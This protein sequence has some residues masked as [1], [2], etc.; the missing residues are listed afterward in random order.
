ME[1]LYLTFKVA[2]AA[3]FAR[4]WDAFPAQG[5][6]M[7]LAVRV[8]GG[9]DVLRQIAKEGPR[10][11][12]VETESVSDPG[13]SV[14]DAEA[15]G[16][17]REAIN[18]AS[19]FPAPFKATLT[20]LLETLQFIEAGSFDLIG[21]KP[22]FKVLYAGNEFVCVVSQLDESGVQV[23]YEV[24]ACNSGSVTD[25]DLSPY[26]IRSGQ[27]GFPREEREAVTEHISQPGK[28]FADF[29]RRDLAIGDEF[30]AVHNSSPSVGAHW[31]GLETAEGVLLSAD[32]VEPT[33]GEPQGGGDA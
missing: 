23:K 31:D 8:P 7:H 2:D 26:E 29:L 27:I 19:G 4:L 16:Q 24:Q 18:P 22:G 3:N 21:G 12:P 10:S 11:W 32:A 20:A 30:S 5:M 1:N 28:K 17:L 15:S 33:E 13:G 9:L 6:A 14:S 25:E